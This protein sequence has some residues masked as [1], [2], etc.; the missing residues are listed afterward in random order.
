MCILTLTAVHNPGDGGGKRGVVATLGDM[1]GLE[2][3]FTH[4]VSMIDNSA[5]NADKAYKDSKL[6]NVLTTQHLA[7]Q[8]QA[9]QAR[10]TCNCFSPG[11]IPT[12]GL[13]REYNPYLV[14][15]FAY[16]MK[17]LFPVAVTEEEGGRRL[18][19]M[20]ASD[21]LKGVSGKYYSKPRASKEFVVIDPSEEARHLQQATKLW[22]LTLN[23]IAKLELA[24]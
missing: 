15:V 17:Y 1:S 14:Y 22:I 11:L 24:S 2:A 3:G 19:Y 9:K 16:T 12:T 4:P 7:R 5:F 23:I 8:L 18:A 6:C 13:F 20:I 21:D 10:V